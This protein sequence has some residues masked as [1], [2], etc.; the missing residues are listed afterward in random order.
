MKGIAQQST[1]PKIMV[2]PTAQNIKGPLLDSFAS[3][4]TKGIANHKQ[5]LGKHLQRKELRVDA[6]IISVHEGSL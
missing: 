2:L 3:I 1:Q 4:K 6:H 5:G